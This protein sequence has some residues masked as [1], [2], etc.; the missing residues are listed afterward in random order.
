MTHATIV[1]C[2]IHC[3]DSQQ[4]T[5]TS[6]ILEQAVEYEVW[7][8][9]IEAW[10][11]K[12]G[13]IHEA[14]KANGLQLYKLLLHAHRRKREDVTHAPPSRGPRGTL[15]RPLPLPLSLRTQPAL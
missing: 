13:G 14:D 5:H 11:W 2:D 15:S 4:Q 6:S 1:T 12:G 10:N 7:A 8:L 3:S 9:E